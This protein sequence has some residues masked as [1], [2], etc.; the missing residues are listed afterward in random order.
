MSL[1][2]GDRFRHDRFR[3]AV[4]GVRVADS[5]YQLMQ[6][7]RVTKALVY[8]RVADGDTKGQWVADRTDAEHRF[9][10]RIESP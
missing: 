9:I 6:V 3:E 1:A 7:T 5:P 8:Y 10:P 2:K 4:P